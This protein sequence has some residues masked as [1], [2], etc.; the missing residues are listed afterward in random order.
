MSFLLPQEQVAGCYP[1]TMSDL[2]RQC[3]AV[4]ERC[5]LPDWQGFHYLSDLKDAD[6]SSVHVLGGV[7][8]LPDGRLV[9]DQSA[10]LQLGQLSEFLA[11]SFASVGAMPGKPCSWETGSG[12]A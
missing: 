4:F 6:P 12:S 5:F 3:S 11:A 8:W 1:D 10:P 7:S 9:S 2:Y